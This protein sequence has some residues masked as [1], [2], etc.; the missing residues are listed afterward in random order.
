MNWIDIA[1]MIAPAAPALGGILGG[2]V[3]VPGGALAGQ[4][5]G[6]VIARALGVSATPDAVAAAVGATPNDVLVAKLN[7]AADE[8]RAQWPAFAQAEQ[9]YFDAQAKA[10]ESVN[11]TMRAE[12]GNEHWFFTGWRAASGWVFVASAGTFACILM[13]ATARAVALAS[14]PLKAISD[15]WP[16]YVAFFGILAAMVGVYI[17]GRA[18]EKPKPVETLT[19]KPAVKR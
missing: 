9:A 15:A 11:T 4:A 17:I 6:N 7:A 14:D 10:A 2:F 3:P 16:I 5:L 13:W 19:T 1:R 12:L 18:P 8:A